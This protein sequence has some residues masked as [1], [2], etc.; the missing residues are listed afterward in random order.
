MS[1]FRLES[2]PMRLTGS[3]DQESGEPMYELSRGDPY[4]APPDMPPFGFSCSGPLCAY[5]SAEC[6]MTLAL[7]EALQGAGVDNLQVFPAV[8]TDSATGEVR[9]DYRVVNI[10]GKVAAADMKRS[11]AI[12]R[13]GGQV[14]TRLTIDPGRARGL[15]MFRLAESLIDVIVHG[16]VA[17]AIAAGQFPAVALTA[18]TPE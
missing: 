10:V 18:V 7:V 3:V 9:E 2:D 16:K 14:V 1:Y 17:R 15:L 8:L 4:P 5:Y 13:G 6:L 11:Q 12:S